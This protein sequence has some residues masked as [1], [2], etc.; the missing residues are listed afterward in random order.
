MLSTPLQTVGFLRAY[1]FLSE[2]GNPRGG[3]P[4]DTLGLQTKLEPTRTELLEGDES[5]QGLG[6]HPLRKRPSGIGACEW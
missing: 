1:N 5:L 4:E 2:L 6:P 3:R